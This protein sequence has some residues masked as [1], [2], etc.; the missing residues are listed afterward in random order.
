MWIKKWFLFDIFYDSFGQQFRN[1]LPKTVKESELRFFWNHNW[2][3]PNLVTDLYYKIH[4][5]LLCLLFHGPLP[6]QVR[7]SYKEGPRGYRPL[8]LTVFSAFGFGR[9]ERNGKKKLVAPALISGDHKFPCRR[10]KSE[11]GQYRQRACSHILTQGGLTSAFN[12]MI[13]CSIPK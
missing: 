11:F 8:Y 9:R 1:P 12:P 5:T 4:A 3:N 10:D 7:T 2:H 13:A 6:P